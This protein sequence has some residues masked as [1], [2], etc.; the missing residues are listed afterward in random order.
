MRNI[1]RLAV[2][3]LHVTF[4]I[5]GIALSI[6]AHIAI[7]KVFVAWNELIYL[8]PMIDFS[9]IMMIGLVVLVACALLESWYASI[10]R[11]MVRSMR[12]LRVSYVTLCILT[13][14][15]TAVTT[16]F[17]VVTGLLHPTMVAAVML[18]VWLNVL[19]MV[20]LRGM[21]IS[22]GRRMESTRDGPAA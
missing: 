8:K 4:I 19:W 20:V 12:W 3:L 22:L 18:M 17:Y 2:L 1:T 11:S 14:Y 21:I 9:I 7:D 6:F 15:I 10:M 5:I 13:I 16:I